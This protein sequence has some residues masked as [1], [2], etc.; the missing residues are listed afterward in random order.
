MSTL[1]KYSSLD[2]I[3]ITRGIQFK[4][5]YKAQ[6]CLVV[7][8][9]NHAVVIVYI[10]TLYHIVIV[11]VVTVYHIV[12]VYIVTLYHIVIVYVV[13]VYHIV[14]VPRDV[15]SGSELLTVHCL[16]NLCNTRHGP[17]TLPSDVGQNIL[18]DTIFRDLALLTISGRVIF[19]S[20]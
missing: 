15:F 9:T 8:P 12:I 1:F 13:T 2:L 18:Y 10:V 6:N 20:F 5:F 4:H 7:V 11:Y 19:Y 16:T 14:L 17:A 3:K